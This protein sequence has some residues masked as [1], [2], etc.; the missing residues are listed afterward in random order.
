MPIHIRL[1]LP[2]ARSEVTAML[3]TGADE[4]FIL[5]RF[6]LEAGWELTRNLEQPVKFVDGQVTTCFAI[7]NLD[8][9][10]IDTKG[11]EKNY[12]LWFYVINMTGFEAILGKTW[13]WDEDPMILTWRGQKWQF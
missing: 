4:N 6:L 10:V 11:R 9:T 3:D 7:L 12:P 13:L 8:T 2:E 1:N 5:Y